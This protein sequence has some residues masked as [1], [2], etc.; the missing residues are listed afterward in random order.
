MKG[1]KPM[2]KKI[3]T[4]LIV[5]AV[6]VSFSVYAQQ[7]VQ[8]TQ[9]MFNGLVINPA[10]AGADEAL[11]LTFLQ[12]NQWSGVENAP[13]TQT[14]SAHTLFKKKHFGLGLTF[15]NDKI[16]VHKNVS[17]LSNYAY[18]LKVG[19]KSFLSMGLQAGIH[20]LRSDYASL[21]SSTSND[22]RVYGSYISRT[23]FDFGAGLYFRSPRLHVGLSAPE[24]IPETVNLNDSIS[25]HLNKTNMFLF[26]KYRITLSE[27]VDMEPAVLVKRLTGVPISYDINANFI[28]RKVLT[29]GLS[30]RRKESV[31]FLMKAQ[32][33]PQLQ[34]GYAYDHPT[35]IVSRISN[36]SHELMVNYLFRYVRSKV[37]S[38]R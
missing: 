3:S 19:A 36:G 34:V 38:P 24:L 12:R 7:K 20:S 35:G 2:L 26:S 4:G 37:S 11:S 10:Y 5:C 30:Y 14:L 28:Y 6:L 13:S 22:P 15:I 23:F 16:G 27:I 9:Y 18:H 25:V 17:A 33:T 29:M 32:I 8:F 31:D 1:V 21:L